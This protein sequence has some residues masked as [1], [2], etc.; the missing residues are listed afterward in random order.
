MALCG[1]ATL[2]EIGPDLV[3]VSSSPTAA[4]VSSRLGVADERLLLCPAGAPDWRYLVLEDPLPAGVEALQDDT[5]YPLE[6]PEGRSWGSRVEYR[7]Q[8]TVFFQED[9]SEGRYEYQYLVRVISSGT[10]RAR[11]AQISPMY[12]PG[13]SASSEPLT[14]TVPAT[15]CEFGGYVV[16][17]RAPFL[18]SDTEREA[19]IAADPT[20][21][22]T[23]A[24]DADS[25]E[26]F[27]IVTPPAP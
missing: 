13:V 9:F 18:V 20:N 11:P 8:Q 14:L 19:V 24:F 3:V 23:G 1:A 7:D 6:A 21:G 10:F 17:A 5:A 26:P 2:G 27:E 22:E 4:L 12:V 16:L 25:C 15:H